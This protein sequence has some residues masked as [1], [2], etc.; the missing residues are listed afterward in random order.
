MK[1]CISCDLKRSFSLMPEVRNVRNV[2]N[3]SVSHRVAGHPLFPKVPPRLGGPGAW[4]CHILQPESDG[5]AMA[6]ALIRLELWRG[7]SCPT[8][9][10][11]RPQ[12][13]L[14][15]WLPT[16]WCNETNCNSHRCKQGWALRKLL[17]E[18]Q[19]C[20][21]SQKTFSDFLGVSPCT[22]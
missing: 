8:L 18:I 19:W 6:V 10:P 9:R 7:F 15:G 20:F 14:V 22:I 4:V 1:S 3:V 21:F 5:F 13:G 17:P 2:R 12:L 11:Q 16:N